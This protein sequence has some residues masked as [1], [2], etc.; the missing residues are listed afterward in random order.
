MK[1]KDYVRLGGISIKSRKKSTRNTV[2]GISFGLIMIIPV[3]FFAMAFYMNI[4]NVVNDI[5]NVSAFKVLCVGNTSDYE[6]GYMGNVMPV[7]GSKDYE[8]LK[9][10]VGGDIEEIV[11]NEY[12]NVSDRSQTIIEEKTKFLFN[13]AIYVDDVFYN[14]PQKIKMVECSRKNQEVIPDAIISDLN[15]SGKEFLVA[16]SGFS[17]DA[18]GEVMLSEV[19]VEEFGFNPEQAIGKKFTLKV[20]ES[21]SDGYA[22]DN[23]NNPFNEYEGENTGNFQAEAISNFKVVGVISKDYYKLSE[24]F[25]Y[26]AHIWISEDSVYV[27]ENGK[28]YNKY[29]PQISVVEKDEALPDKWSGTVFT[30]SESLSAL[31]E[32]AR[33]EKMFFPAM[34][35]IKFSEDGVSYNIPY[36][37]SSSLFI[38]CKD[39]SSAKKVSSYLDSVYKKITNYGTDYKFFYASYSFVNFLFINTLGDYVTIAFMILGG[40]IL[41]ATLLNLYNSVSYSVQSRKNYLGM[42]RAIGAKESIIRRL[43]F[44]EILMIF[45]R[46][47]IWVLIF[48]GGICYVIK[49]FFDNTFISDESIFG[50]ILILDFKYFFIALLIVAAAIFLV[51]FLFSLIACMNVTKKPVL[52]VLSDEK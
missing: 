43:Y 39:Y 52:E 36:R 50:N 10:M 25:M 34:P 17:E 22:I 7:L 24:I 2:W 47:L 44:L 14:I 5:K 51:A 6:S 3:V 38:Q 45:L 41:F 16:G 1:L 31:E 40:V 9:T 15:E 42:M 11:Y 23:D 37:S 49:Y 35:G 13:K 12:F 28:P 4:Y 18:R 21:L 29:L 32:K 8:E 33:N 30:Y 26:D 27:Y 20:S 19:I 48:A 46:S